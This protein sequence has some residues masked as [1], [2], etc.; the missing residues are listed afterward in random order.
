MVRINDTLLDYAG[1][2]RF[3]DDLIVIE[4]NHFFDDDVIIK[5]NLAHASLMI[6]PG[7]P[8]DIRTIGYIAY[9]DITDDEYSVDLTPVGEDGPMF[10]DDNAVEYPED[11][12][13]GTFVIESSDDSYDVEVNN[14]SIGIWSTEDSY[15]MYFEEVLPS[16][17]Y[18][19]I[20]I[21][22]EAFSKLYKQFMLNDTMTIYDIL[23]I[24]GVIQTGSP[25]NLRDKLI[26]LS[27]SK[28]YDNYGF[29]IPDSEETDTTDA[30]LAT[31]LSEIIASSITET[32]TNP[33]YTLPET[34]SSDT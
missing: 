10:S 34:D 33:D 11:A 4:L 29:S 13:K 8:S 32:W 21:N 9:D 22:A 2:I 23:R 3:S 20:T 7:S 25:L 17:P 16:A 14:S 30:V 28:R 24:T 1:V 12:D 26:L 19:V 31:E 5:D 18:E 27:E 6:G 15:A